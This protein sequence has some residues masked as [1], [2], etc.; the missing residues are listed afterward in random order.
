VTRHHRRILGAAASSVALLALAACGGSGTGASSGGDASPGVSD[1]QI[2]IASTIASTGNF[3][4]VT[5]PYIS[6]ANA[7]FAKVNEDGGVEGRDIVWNHI[8]DGYD[9]QRAVAGAQKIA[10]Q[11]SSFIAALPFGTATTLATSEVYAAKGIPNVT[12]GTALAELEGKNAATTFGCTTPYHYQTRAAVQWTAENMPA[13]P[14][15][16]MTYETGDG[17]DVANALTK[18]QE[19]EGL[20]VVDQIAY[21]PGTTDFSGQLDQLKK[22]GAKYVVLYG[23]TPDA[24]RIITAAK[25]AGLDATFVGPMPLADP[26]F[27]N[28]SKGQAEG[29]IVASPY[30]ALTSDTEGIKTFESDLQQYGDKNAKPTLWALHGYNCASIVAEG[31]K[32]AGENPTR[33]SFIKGMESIKDFDNGVTAPVTFGE[34]DHRASTSSIVLQVEDGAFVQKSGDWISFDDE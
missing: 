21:A 2:T 3:A 19:A 31:L 28:L 25:A 34:G 4:V 15:A 1:D 26:D 20:D 22:S 33:E 7:Y 16:S 6:A 10:Q 23:S 24:A 12:L 32:N 11:D 29:T 30:Q 8:D 5:G 27:L 18:E 13:G 9:I 14:W 17:E